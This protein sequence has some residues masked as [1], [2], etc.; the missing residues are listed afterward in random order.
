M[1]YDLDFKIKVIAY[2]KQGYS[3]GAT[4]EKFAVNPWFISKWAKKYQHGSIDAIKPRVSKIKYS[5]DFKYKII[6]LMLTEGLSQSETALKF[7]ISSPALISHWR[8]LW[9]RI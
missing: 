1:R 8:K 2:Y 3:V 6:A 5:A 9:V 7:H 4:D